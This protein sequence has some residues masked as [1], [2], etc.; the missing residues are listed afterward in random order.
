MIMVAEVSGGLARVVGTQGT[1]RSA[2]SLHA[3]PF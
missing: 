1:Q 2:Q 3:M